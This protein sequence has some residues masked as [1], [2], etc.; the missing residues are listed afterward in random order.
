MSKVQ[1]KRTITIHNQEYD[2]YSFIIHRVFSYRFRGRLPTQDTTLLFPNTHLNPTA[3][4]S[5]IMTLKSL[6]SNPINK[7]LNL[8]I[9]ASP[10]LLIYFSFSESSTFYKSN[11]N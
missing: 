5:A 1:I 2:L 11:K 4:G 9:T 6:N 10:I 8:W 7:S 3:N